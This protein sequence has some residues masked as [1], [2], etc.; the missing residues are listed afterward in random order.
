MPDPQVWL[1]GLGCAAVLALPQV[2][3]V[4]AAPSS[5]V[6]PGTAPQLPALLPL[7]QDLQQV[8]VSGPNLNETSIVSG[9]Y[10][11]TAEGIIPTSTIKGRLGH[12]TGA[13]GRGW[14]CLPRAVPLLARRQR[15]R[16]RLCRGKE[17]TAHL[18][19]LLLPARLREPAGK[20]VC[21]S[22]RRAWDPGPSAGAWLM[23]V[24]GGEG[25]VWA[26]GQKL[27]LEP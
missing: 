2:L 17:G 18:A 12:S 7:L 27:R 20:E 3:S 8:M 1:S 6:C 4:R 9:G 24:P 21:C 13:R 26:H 11:G 15:W 14:G 22:S 19:V 23:V 16:E 10:G 5:A 25:L